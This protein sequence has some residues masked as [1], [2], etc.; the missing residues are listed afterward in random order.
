MSDA[1]NLAGAGTQRWDL[2]S[3][4]LFA[5]AVDATIF[6][7]TVKPLGVTGQYF[8]RATAAGLIAT[9]LVVSHRAACA[10]LGLALRGFGADLK[11][12][13]MVVAALLG[14]SIA[15]M[16]VAV[17]VIRI[18][19][20]PLTDW[21]REM[22]S[23]SQIPEY[24]LNG[25]LLAPLVE[26]FVYR[27]L[28]VPGLSREYGRRGAVVAGALVFYTLHL[29]YAQ[30]LWMVH[31]LVAGA[32]LTW[33]FVQRGKLWICIVLHAGG[34]VMVLL[35]DALLIWAPDVFRA[36]VGKLPPP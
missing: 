5:F 20:L 11:W 15:A 18:F 1:P 8:A 28:M 14:L 36:L 9:F 24:L 21:P 32:I 26:E 34:N 6:F 13:A 30:P 16:A 22:R 23:A 29:V 3:A 27:G 4:A 7:F 35:D 17:G 31:Y 2:Y 25:V 19:D 10:D 12:L 33:A